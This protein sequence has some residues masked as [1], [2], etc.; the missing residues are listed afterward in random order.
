METS[1]RYLDNA[2]TYIAA[3]ET[4][5][6]NDPVAAKHFIAPTLLLTGFAVELFLK[7]VVLRDRKGATTESIRKEFGHKLYK[8]WNSEEAKPI[9]DQSVHVVTQVHQDLSS[10]Y[11]P[12]ENRLPNNPDF[13][14]NLARPLPK[15]KRLNPS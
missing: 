10:T 13:I 3:A 6:G 5:D 9:R 4:L 2:L 7:A 11:V 14:P 8:L 12:P 15:P 1:K